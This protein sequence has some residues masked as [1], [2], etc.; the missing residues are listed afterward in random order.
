MERKVWRNSSGAKVVFLAFLWLATISA[1]AGSYPMIRGLVDDSAL[2]AGLDNALSGRVGSSAIED[3]SCWTSIVLPGSSASAHL[4]H[5]KI[6]LLMVLPPAPPDDRSHLVNTVDGETSFDATR[7][8]KR[9]SLQDALHAFKMR[10]LPNPASD[11]ATFIVWGICWCRVGGLRVEVYDTSGRCVFARESTEPIQEWNLHT[12]DGSS[13][14][15]GVYLV[16]GLIQVDG[17]WRDTGVQKLV[18]RR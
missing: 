7:G 4:S 8:E 18:V 2:V 3:A 12:S 6:S 14:A 16:H 15:N 13:L 17:L 5:S 1:R 10:I 9:P 11:K